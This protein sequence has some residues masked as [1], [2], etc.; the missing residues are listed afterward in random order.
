MS[1]TMEKKGKKLKPIKVEFACGQN[2]DKGWIGVDIEKTPQAD[3]V[4]D[5]EQYPWPF[6][7][8]YIDEARI[9]H[10]VEHVKDLIPFMN[11]LYRVMKPGGKCQIITP[12]Y[13]SIRCW[14]DPTHVRAISEVT[15]MY[16]NK[17]W[18]EQNKLDHYPIT[19]DFDFTYGYNIDPA[20]ANRS[21]EA[22]NFAIK[23]Y[24][25]V[26]QDILVTLTKK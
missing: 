3:V 25:N 1:T 11:E 21:E 7:D 4:H 10:Y 16:F 26:V 15:F 19:A 12:Y 2:K 22:R 8:N 6:K 17:V 23:H 13:S 18:R 14:Q 20:W 24:I 5:L 9:S